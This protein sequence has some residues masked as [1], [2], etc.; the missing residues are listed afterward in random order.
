MSSNRI[1]ISPDL[2]IP[3]DET[4]S[5]VLAERNI[6]RA[7]LA[8]RTGV[9]LAYVDSIIAG[10][11]DISSEFAVALEDVLGVPKSFWMNLQRNFEREKAELE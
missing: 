4:I 3:P 11:R 6:T 2:L 9:S 10:E 7:E 8:A 1:N 5:D